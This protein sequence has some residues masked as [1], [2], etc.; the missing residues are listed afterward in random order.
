MLFRSRDARVTPEEMSAALL[1]RCD[2][3][4]LRRYRRDYR[5]FFPAA[6][7]WLRPLENALRWLPLGAQ[8]FVALR[9]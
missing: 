9:K 3:A 6:L 5:V 1:Q 2:S 4:G 8:Y 7:A